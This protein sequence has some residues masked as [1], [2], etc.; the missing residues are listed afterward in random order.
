M[1]AKAK[2]SIK[3]IEQLT[4]KQQ[5]A[6]CFEYLAEQNGAE[7]NRVHEAVP[8]IYGKFK[9]ADYTDW[10]DCFKNICLII[11]LEYWRLSTHRMAALLT[12]AENDTETGDLAAANVN[13]LQRKR[14]ALQA[15]LSNLCSEHGFNYVAARKLA[16]LPPE[17][18][19]DDAALE[20]AYYNQW[21]KDLSEC[22]PVTKQSSHS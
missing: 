7:A 21:Y 9:L 5:A 15:A 13:A 8:W 16:G 14:N 10:R 11:G 6:M 2:R 19:I 3:L 18:R 12:M 20:E 1:N 4:P 17:Q 22:L